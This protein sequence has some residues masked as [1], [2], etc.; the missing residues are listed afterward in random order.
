MK[1]LLSVFLILFFITGCNQEKQ[2]EKV[3]IKT[4]VIEQQ[5][6]GVEKKQGEKIEPV[7][8]AINPSDKL[9]LTGKGQLI[10]IDAGHQ[11]YGN[12]EQEPIGPG[13]TKMKAKVTS[14]ATGIATG[15]LES[16][17]NLEV[18]LKLKEKLEDSGYR[19]IMVRTN[20]NVDISNSERAKIAN[21]NNADAFIRLHCNSDDSSNTRGALTI[22]PSNNN[23][24]CSQISDA[25]Q[26]LSKYV[27]D[28]IC[29]ITKAKNRGV[30]I[31]DTMS[32]INWCQ[33]PV[34][35]V[36]M[37]F[38]SNSEED[39]LLSN[40]DYQNKIAIGIV[41]GINEFMN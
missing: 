33:V 9:P 18:A 16:Q 29:D 1:K 39:N 6:S 41:K 4:K 17:I 26:L 13:A 11:R 34:T 23:R 22:A 28:N 12:N 15:R 8:P 27:L 35:I 7:I 32:G 20:Q 14:G 2:I 37:G 24:F 25:S 38:I 36:E 30:M 40:N 10:V 21:E 31:N 3:V 5:H 19:V